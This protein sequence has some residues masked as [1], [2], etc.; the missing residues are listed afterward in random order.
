ML[1]LVIPK[2]SDFFK[3][4]FVV[5]GWMTDQV[6]H[7]GHPMEPGRHSGESRNPEV[8]RSYNHWNRLT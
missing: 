8:Q 7:D 2:M 4:M 1:I 3:L 6:L 5:Y